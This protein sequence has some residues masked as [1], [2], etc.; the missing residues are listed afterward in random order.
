MAADGHSVAY[1]RYSVIQLRSL[2]IDNINSVWSLQEIIFD[3]SQ[4]SILLKVLT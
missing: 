2:A 4:V 1:L 3:L